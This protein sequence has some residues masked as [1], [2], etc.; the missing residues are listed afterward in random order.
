[1]SDSG[2]ALQLIKQYLP[3]ASI[4]I[5]FIAPLVTTIIL[6]SNV[7]TADSNQQI[8]KYVG[9]TAPVIILSMIFLAIG[10][11]VYFSRNPEYVVY[12]AITAAI[13]AM[14]IASLSLCI[15][16]IDKQVS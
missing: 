6:T 9:I 14:G 12:F 16:S 2:S 11:W 3:H 7:G 1:M 8:R 10:S 4:F 13:F 5:G 15:A